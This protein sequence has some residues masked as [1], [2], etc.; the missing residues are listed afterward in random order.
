MFNVAQGCPV[1]VLKE[2][3]KISFCRNGLAESEQRK[4]FPHIEFIKMYINLKDT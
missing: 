4:I 1:M 2:Y 3:C